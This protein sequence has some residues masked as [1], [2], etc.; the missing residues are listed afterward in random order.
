[1]ASATDQGEN[2]MADEQDDERD[3]PQQLP[4]RM[5]G[6]A[7]ADKSGFFHIY[8]SGQGYWTRMLTA[9][10]VALVTIFV[11]Q[12]CY[13]Q[14]PVLVQSLQRHPNVKIGITVGVVLAIAL[15]TFLVMNRPRNADFLIATDS[16]MKKVNW[17]SRKELIGSTKVVVIFLFAITLLLFV[18]DLVFGFVFNKLGVLEVNPLDAFFKK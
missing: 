7:P 15:V 8:K 14:L 5:T 17:T 18:L 10:G 4:A 2:K 6:A 3:Q 13:S 12:F 9:G 11:A 1:M 16:E